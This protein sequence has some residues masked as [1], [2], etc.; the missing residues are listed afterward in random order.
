[1]GIIGILGNVCLI[2]WF[3]KK[4]KNFHRLMQALATCDLG[5]I[6][7]SFIVFGIPNLFVGYAE[8]IR[9]S[10]QRKKVHI[11][12]RFAENRSYLQ[13]VPILLPL[14]H[15]S[16]SSS[17]YLT[18]AIAVERYTTVCHPFFKV[19]CKVQSINQMKCQSWL[20]RKKGNLLL[21]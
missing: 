2:V 21:C 19:R 7:S 3:W 14:A 18:L 1:M 9:L 8:S 15:L 6:I 10:H 16:L 13:L 20:F 17:I 5:Y 4:K 12:F 11:F